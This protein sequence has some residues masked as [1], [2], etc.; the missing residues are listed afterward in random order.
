MSLRK[1]IVS[2]F[3][4]TASTILFP[5]ITFP[6][7]TRTLSNASIGKVFFIDA[8]T[9]YFIIFSAIG[10]PFYG[11]REVA[12][13]KNDVERR[14]KLVIELLLLQVILS[15]VFSSLFIGIHFFIPQLKGSWDLI[16]ISC[17]TIIANAFLIEW[18]YQGIENFAYITKRSLIIK[19]LSV[20]SILVLVKADHDYTIYYLI[21]SAVVL[22]NAML[23]TGN[24]FKKFHAKFNDKLNVKQHLKPLLILFSINVSV[25]IYAIL[26]TVILG[27]LTSD[28][29][30]S[31]YNVPLK[32][33]KMYWLVVSGVG[34][35]LIP[36]MSA[37]FVEKDVDG[38]SALL[39][40]SL[41]IVFLLTLPF[42]F[43]CIFFS[44]EILF[45][46]AGEK[47]LHATLVIKILSVVPLIIGVCNVMGTQFLLP[48]GHE[49]KILYATIIGLIISLAFNF[50]LIPHLKSEG[51]AITCV[52]AEGAVCLFMVFAA[53]KQMKIK[54]DSPLLLQ[55]VLT[56]VITAIIIC[57]VQNYF[58]NLTLLIIAVCVYLMVFAVMQFGIFKN[59]FIN[60]LVKLK[61]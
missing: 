46:I 40:K 31:L 17:L 12:R 9:Q 44:K 37:L 30:V 52:L 29:D 47:Y 23:N 42:C 21:L 14:S 15:V 39:S 13:I 61:R 36:R 11:V 25:S 35:T 8:F 59:A 57:I 27:F 6:Y 60:S 3:I 24:Y 58:L 41:S 16:K 4:L 33:V 22:F 38:I 19:V 26:D 7:I 56:I 5:L 43:F 34:T 50:A 32:L 28:K 20:V 2:N 53:N 54:V 18:F 48:I 55:I 1:N 10:I 51:A 45:L 49:R